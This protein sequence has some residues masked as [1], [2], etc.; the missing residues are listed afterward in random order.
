MGARSR[1]TLTLS[2]GAPAP[3]PSALG[4]GHTHQLRR[5]QIGAVEHVWAPS[6][7]FYIP[8][9]HQEMIGEK[10]VGAMLL[11]LA[12]GDYRLDFVCPQGV[13]RNS[14][15]DQVDIYPQLLTQEFL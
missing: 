6:C 10:V 12:S 14:L 2:A 7:A 15:L 13:A 1:S 3:G 9:C 11:T 4:F 5:H 8:D